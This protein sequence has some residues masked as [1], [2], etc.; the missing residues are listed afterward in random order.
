MFESLALDL[1]RT[2][3]T[4]R[5][6]R[7]ADLSRYVV[8]LMDRNLFERSCDVRWWA[9]DAAVVD[10][11]ENPDNGEI[12]SQTSQR[13][14]VILDSYTVYLDLWIADCNGRIIATGR[15][16]NTVLS[17]Q[18]SVTCR[19][20]AKPCDA[21]MAGRMRLRISRTMSC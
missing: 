3:Q 19:G 7:F 17:V 18:I 16:I 5:G 20:S 2:A 21:G 14:G 12:A 11:C 4:A 6:D 13:L 9:T 15:R 1:E 10:V 8:E